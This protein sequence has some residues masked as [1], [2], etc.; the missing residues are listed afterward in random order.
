MFFDA[1]ESKHIAASF[2]SRAPAIYSS[3]LKAN[4]LSLN[5]TIDN[6]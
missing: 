1:D 4:S 6:A 5:K 3:D 2:S